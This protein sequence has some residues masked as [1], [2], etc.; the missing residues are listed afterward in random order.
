MLQCFKFYSNRPKIRKELNM[1]YMLVRAKFEDYARFYPI[2]TDHAPVRQAS[3][4]RG[5]RLFRNVENPDE[6]LALFEWDGLEKARQF[7]GS[8][9]LRQ[10]MQRAGLADMPTV[11]FLDEVE[12]TPA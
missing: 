3:G 6:V 8:D 2:Y 1:P 12:R 11:Y 5:A 4:S 9:D 10:A 7:A